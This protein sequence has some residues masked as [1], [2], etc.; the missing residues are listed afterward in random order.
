LQTLAERSPVP[1]TIAARP[2]ARLP[3]PV[4]AAA[5]FLVSEA[6]ANVAKYAHASGVRVS[7]VDLDGRIL[8]DVDDDGVGGADPSNGY[9]LR[10]LS[11]RVHA[12]DGELDVASP[13]GRG[14]HV[15][16]EIPCVSS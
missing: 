6:L 14:T 7:V 12:L 10:G 4:E 9:G 15:H 8:V 16:A 13:P 3:A 11:D 2:E 5:Y 1:A